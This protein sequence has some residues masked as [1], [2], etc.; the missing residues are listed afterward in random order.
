MVVML[1]AKS[2]V[3]YQPLDALNS[4]NVPCSRLQESRCIADR[5]SELAPRT[6]CR[7]D[8]PDTSA[9]T[10]RRACT[11]TCLNHAIFPQ[12]RHLSSTTPSCLNHAILPQPRHLAAVTA[13]LEAPQNAVHS[14]QGI[15]VLG[16]QYPGSS[17]CGLRLA[18]LYHSTPSLSY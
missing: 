18:P 12:P 14:K 4:P 13:S 8:P 1:T 11:V 6:H 15:A 3:S 9:G 7:V 16:A 2:R 5:T 10:K 17:R